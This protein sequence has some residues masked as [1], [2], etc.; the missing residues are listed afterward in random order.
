MSASVKVTSLQSDIPNTS[1]VAAPVQA[2]VQQAEQA[3]ADNSAR[4]SLRESQAASE[5]AQTILALLATFGSIRA[6]IVQAR[7]DAERLTA[8][9]YRLDASHAALDTAQTGL[10]R[11]AEELQKLEGGESGEGSEGSEGGSTEALTSRVQEML[12]QAQ[13]ALDEAISNGRDLP[14]LR[15]ENERRLNELDALGKDLAHAIVEGRKTFAIVNE[16][17]EST[18]DDIRGNGSEAEAVADRA[19][20]HWTAARRRNTMEAQEFQAA[21]EDLDATG[22]ELAYARELVDAITRRLEDLQQARDTARTELAD[23][24]SDIESGWRFI[25]ENDDDI[26]KEP[27]HKL[28]E[29]AELLE[30]ARAEM[31]KDKPDWLLLV[32]K[33]QHANRLADEA[34]AGARSEYEA[35]DKLRTHAQRA[36]QVAAAEV[37]KVVKFADLHKED[38][39]PQ[40][41]QQVQ[42]L[43]QQAQQAAAALQ[44]AHESEEDERRAALQESLDSYTSINQE[45]GRVYQAVRADFQ[46][47]EQL[48][49]ELNQEL[50]NARQAIASAERE[51]EQYNI[52]RHS[53]E[54]Q[55]LQRIRQRF[56]RIKLPI[57]GEKN[58]RSTLNMARSF[59]QE[60]SDVRSAMHANHRAMHRHHDHHDSGVGDVVAGMALGMLIDAATR[61][62]GWGGS[63][64]WSGGDGGD[65]GGWGDWGGSGGGGGIDWG[66]GGGGGIDW[67]GGGGG[68]IDW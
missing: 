13:A 51:L 31:D 41:Q 63:G 18:W 14:K 6:G 53:Q 28:H 11:A 58:L 43:Q 62:G 37:Q 5:M 24:A 15:A 9:G 65:S 25:H 21:S 29:A 66:G 61:G 48:R 23:A 8:E 39:Q 38:M 47:F 2:R 52:S 45:A 40:S 17:A 7:N 20:Q 10:R 27:E 64:S 55:S 30:V 35:M 19:R 33:A 16:F 68:G 26:G 12:E 67:G 59:K 56:D 4:R 57:R 32:E 54:G 50:A 49:T 36:Q 42:R 44:R 3:S 1:A 22:E 34:L 46:R 60:V